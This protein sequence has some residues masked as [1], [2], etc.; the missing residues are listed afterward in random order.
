MG[1]GSEE[2]AWKDAEE[3]ISKFPPIMRVHPGDKI[4]HFYQWDYRRGEPQIV[5]EVNVE[6]G[7]I[8]VKEYIALL[9]PNEITTWPWELEQEGGQQ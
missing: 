9:H 2:Y 4:R 1:R 5:E 8:K 7:W 6:K 3:F